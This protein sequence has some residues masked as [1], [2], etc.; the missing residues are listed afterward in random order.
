MEEKIIYALHDIGKSEI[1]VDL[2]KNM[3]ED[4]ESGKD[5]LPHNMVKSLQRMIEENGNV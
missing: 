5:K 2:A 4:H 1:K 3:L